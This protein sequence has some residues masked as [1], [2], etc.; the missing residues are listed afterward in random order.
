MICSTDYQKGSEVFVL[1]KIK[2]RYKGLNDNGNAVI[3][4]GK[5]SLRD[6]E[7]EVSLNNVSLVG[8]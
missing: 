3:S 7:I 4:L 1:I 8:G 5:V 6:E 2:G